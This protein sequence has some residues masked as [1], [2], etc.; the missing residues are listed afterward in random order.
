MHAERRRQQR[1]HRPEQ[2]R[3]GAQPARVGIDTPA[4]REDLQIREHVRQHEP[5][6]HEPAGGADR[7]LP[8]ARSTQV[9]QP[10]HATY[11]QRSELRDRALSDNS[12]KMIVWMKISNDARN[13]QDFL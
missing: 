9:A 1:P 2:D 6:Q 4:A 5:E 12:N 8:D 3:R 11:L 10:R 13:P 7:L